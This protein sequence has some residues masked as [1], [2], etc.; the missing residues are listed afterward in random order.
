M[1]RSRRGMALATAAGSLLILSGCSAGTEG[2]ETDVT[3]DAGSTETPDSSAGGTCA[4]E[5]IQLIG[6]VRNETNPYEKAWL[7]GGD[8]FA[9]SVGLTQTRLTYDGESPKQQEQLRQTLSTGNP[10]CMVL[11]VL[12]NGD[13]DTAPIVAEV[14]A[15]GA[16]LVTHWNKPADLNPWDGH[17]TWISHITFDGVDAGAQIADA[18]FEEMG[19][20]GG[21]IALQGILDT[22]AAK[23]RFIGLENS[24]EANPGITLLDQ[25]AADFDRTSAFNIT[26]TLITKHGDEIKGVWAANDDMALGALQALEAAGMSDVAVAG[27][28]AVPEAVQAVA[29]GTMT[30]TVSVDGPWQGGIGLAMGYCVLTGGLDMA[31][32]TQEQRAF[33]ARQTLISAENA[34]ENLT[35]TANLADFEC[36]NLFDRVTGP[37]S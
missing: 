35:P 25:Q 26:K 22:S 37:V 20:E 23:D 1:M 11:N 10:E 19:G 27:I 4:P 7:D 13:S 33:F 6:Q 15:A 9:E 12:P 18:I 2:T 21:I 17:D 32:V 29:D 24:L 28:D 14:D 3:S 16:Y 36:G 8:A 31:D 30:A 34:E 5:E